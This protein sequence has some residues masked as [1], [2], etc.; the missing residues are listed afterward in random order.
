MV[1]TILISAVYSIFQMVLEGL[2]FGTVAIANTILDESITVFTSNNVGINIFYRFASLIP[3]DNI[4]DI[5]TSIRAIAYSIVVLFMIL[6]AI[7]SMAAPIISEN[8]PNPAQ[9]LIRGVIAIILIFLIFGNTPDYFF[10][11]NLLTRLGGLCGSILSAIPKADNFDL[12]VSLPNLNPAYYLVNI[13]LMVTLIISVFGAALTYLERVLSLAVSVIIGPVAVAMYVNPDTADTAKQ[14]ALSILTQFLA[15]FISLAMWTAFLNQLSAA[16]ADKPLLSDSGGELFAFAVAIAILS[17][18]KNSEKILNTFGLR[19]MNL[20]DSARMVMGGVSTIAGA[21]MMASRF[22]NHRN[23]TNKKS[24]FEQQ[25]NPSD[26][27]YDA[28]GSISNKYDKRTNLLGTGSIGG[29]I[30]NGVDFSY[31]KKHRA[32]GNAISSLGSSI[33]KEV[34]A[35]TIN[36]AFGFSPTSKLQAVGNTSGI[37]KPIEFDTGYH[38]DSSNPKSPNIVANGWMGDFTYTNNGVSKTINDAIVLG[39]NSNTILKEG[40]F[41]GVNSKGESRYIASTSYVV[42]GKNGRIY[43]TMSSSDYEKFKENNSQKIVKSTYR[44]QNNEHRRGYK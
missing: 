28:Q 39:D 12:A 4:V 19:T 15:V 22:K 3:F 29:F 10:G 33:G 24:G 11:D 18:V 17:L 2:L 35:S 34:N 31:V 41:V 38:T 14:W 1:T 13:I 36:D 37:M 30:S 6:A 23:K 42:D 40:T 32:Q 26:K 5:N 7:K 44:R 27:V 25:E 16:F 20:G 8:T 21:A 43:N 9:I